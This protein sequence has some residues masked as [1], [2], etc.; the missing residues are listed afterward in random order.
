MRKLLPVIMTLVIILASLTGCVDG[1]LSSLQNKKTLTIDGPY[2]VAGTIYPYEDNTESFYYISAQYI[3]DET[4]AGYMESVDLNG[5]DTL[6]QMVVKNGCT[7][8]DVSDSTGSYSYYCDGNL[9]TEPRVNIIQGQT[10]YT[11]FQ[12]LLAKVVY[13]E[14]LTGESG[15]YTHLI[16][17]LDNNARDIDCIKD[18]SGAVQKLNSSYPFNEYVFNIA[19]LAAPETPSLDISSSTKVNREELINIINT[20]NDYMFAST[21]QAGKV[22]AQ[23]PVLSPEEQASQ[24]TEDPAQPTEPESFMMTEQVATLSDAKD[25]FMKV[26]FSNYV[27]DVEFRAPTGGSYKVESGNVEFMRDDDATKDA[28]YRIPNAEMGTWQ[29]IY[30]K[31]NNDITV[32]TVTDNKIKI[33]GLT[34]SPI[35][36][37]ILTLTPTLTMDQGLDIMY[38][39]HIDIIQNNYTVQSSTNIV[40]T[41]DKAVYNVSLMNVAPGT[42]K[43]R[44]RLEYMYDGQHYINMYSSPDFTVE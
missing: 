4:M 34:L 27:D 23:P 15:P 17:N 44:L 39:Y 12:N 26:T 31:S 9:L 28:Y 11:V 16:S 30:N 33:N 7:K 40:N 29:M 21:V 32:E 2:T 19:Y 6:I 1:D 22:A 36:D 41:K 14:E 13:E 35:Q 3:D 8:C 25:L 10:I 24:P 42:Y 38:E 18:D 20:M 43:A 37:G 5:K